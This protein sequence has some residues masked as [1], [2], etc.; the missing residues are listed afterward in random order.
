LSRPAAFHHPRHRF[1]P[2]SAKVDVVRR[3]W[4][5]SVQ[6]AFKQLLP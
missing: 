3:Q 4:A 5:S 6:L 2:T 1:T